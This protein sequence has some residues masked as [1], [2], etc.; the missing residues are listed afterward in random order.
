M[1]G[2]LDGLRIVEVGEGKAL[3][4]AAKLLCD[5]GAEVI[6]I[7]R[8]GSGDD[9]RAWGPPYLNR[10]DGGEADPSAYFLACNRGKKSVTVDLASAAGR[11][12]IRDLA[13]RSDV[14][15]ENFKVGDLA[16]RG[17]AYDDLKESHPRLVYCSLTGFGR[18]GPYRDRAGYDFIIQAMGGLMSLTG[19]A[20][21]RPGT[22]P[23]K[24]GVA[25][26]DLVT[27][28]Y[29]SVAVLAALAHRDRSGEGQYIDIALLDCQLAML[30]NQA[31]NF[32][33]SGEIPQR[34]GNAHPNIVPYQSFATADGH[35]VVAVG[36]DSQFERLA[37]A[38]GRPELGRDAA[39]S[40]NPA[41]VQNRERL[42]PLITASLKTETNA[43]WLSSL[44][45]AGVPC[46]PINN[47]KA[48]F[49]DPQVRARKIVGTLDHP[50]L[51]PVPTVRGPFRF[52]TLGGTSERPPPLLGEHTDEVLRRVL[53][54]DAR[55]IEAL[56]AAG[57]I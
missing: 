51:G 17:L 40:T 47:L 41:R 5:L 30:A 1:S 4:Y 22:S 21:E 12:L 49:A 46:G 2:A 28:L 54:L 39:F 38:I 13:A 23:Q 6:K 19:E 33:V 42:V 11:D 37:D 14:L 20:A 8:P 53:G 36:N 57:T 29:A 7:E 56:R 25:I 50:R 48:V 31:M 34:L 52:S 24:V 55:E 9:T 10:N 45:A 3:A 16:R 27:G 35:I 26:A 32:L 43:A 44:G 18:H 15:I